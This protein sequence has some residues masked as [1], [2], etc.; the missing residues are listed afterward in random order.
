MGKNIR[1]PQQIPL[2]I[3]NHQIRLPLRTNH[4]SALGRRAGPKQRRRARIRDQVAVVLEEQGAA[5]AVA[6]GGVA[7]R[8]PAEV[9]GGGWGGGV[10]E[11]VAVRVELEGRARGAEGAEG[12]GGGQGEC[13]GREGLGG[14]G[15]VG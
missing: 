2:G 12:A 8:G 7:L 11:D 10:D 3:K 1:I 14:G 5:L 13:A 4:Q 15:V 6:V 9:V